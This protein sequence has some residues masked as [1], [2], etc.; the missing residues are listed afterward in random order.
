MDA[1]YALLLFVVA[2]LLAEP[3][4]AL[5]TREQC[6]ASQQQEEV[7]QCIQNGIY[8]PCDDAGGKWEQA[9]CAGAHTEIAERELAEAERVIESRL[10]RGKA[11][12]QALA[13]FRESQRLWRAYR[14]SYC[15]FTNAAFD[16]EQFNGSSYFHLGYCYWRLTEQ[17]A[18]EL[19]G[20][21][22]Q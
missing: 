4:L 21:V 20:L 14:D 19:Q 9:Q 13:K 17:R 3:A 1:P 10:A 16:L 15:R 8:D 7:I 6:R 2:G 22:T 5:D 12:R 11:Q 18:K